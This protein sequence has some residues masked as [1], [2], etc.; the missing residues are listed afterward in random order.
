MQRDATQIDVPVRLATRGQH[1]P[2][3]DHSQFSDEFTQVV[4][5]PHGDRGYCAS[6]KPSAA[7]PVSP[8]G[9]R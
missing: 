9:D 1:H 7:H 4:M 2:A 6:L 3:V 5:V 8:A